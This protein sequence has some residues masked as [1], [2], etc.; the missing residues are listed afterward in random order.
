MY[1]KYKLLTDVFKYN[2]DVYE[3]S[4]TDKQKYSPSKWNQ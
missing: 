2:F 1:M 3:E 4:L